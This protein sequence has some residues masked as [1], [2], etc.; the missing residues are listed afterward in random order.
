MAVYQTRN[1][2]LQ[3]FGYITDNP[4]VGGLVSQHYWAP[5]NSVSHNDTLVSLTGESFTGRYLAAECN[6][7]AAQAW[8]DAQAAMSAALQRTRPPINSLEASIRV[9]HGDEVLADNSESDGA[10][11]TAFEGW[12]DGHYQ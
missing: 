1:W 8:E 7:T 6:R 10:M 12:I 5:G 3:E 2:F 4:Q 9:V 11:F